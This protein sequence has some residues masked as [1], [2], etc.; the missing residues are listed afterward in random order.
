VGCREIV[1][2]FLQML[3]ELGVVLL[4]LLECPPRGRPRRR[5]PDLPGPSVFPLQRDLLGAVGTGEAEHELA[6]H[7]AADPDA[8]LHQHHTVAEISTADRATTMVM[9]RVS[10]CSTAPAQEF[11]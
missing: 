7:A 4:S 8:G 9:A 5:L 11:E 6:G 2:N 1:F 3:L 10:V